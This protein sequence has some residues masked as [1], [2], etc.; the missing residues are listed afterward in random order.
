MQQITLFEIELR[1]KNQKTNKKRSNSVCVS[2]DGESRVKREICINILHS[3]WV[4]VLDFARKKAREAENLIWII[5]FS[6]CFAVSIQKWLHFACVNANKCNFQLPQKCMRFFFLFFVY[7]DLSEERKCEGQFK[8]KVWLSHHLAWASSAN[9]VPS[10]RLCVFVCS[11]AKIENSKR[12]EEYNNNERKKHSI[13]KLMPFSILSVA[14]LLLLQNKYTYI[15]F[16]TTMMM[17]MA[18]PMSVQR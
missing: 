13:G 6:L 11:L 12:H 16:S 8:L 14:F 5:F 7:G 4:S 17:V 1:E 10:N 15:L 3:Y 18:M 2:V 9:C